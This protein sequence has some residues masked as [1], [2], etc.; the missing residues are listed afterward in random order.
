MVR[1]SS[2]TKPR[3]LRTTTSITNRRSLLPLELRL[4][5]DDSG[6]GDA[7]GRIEGGS[8][9]A[10]PADRVT[11]R[12]VRLALGDD[13]RGRLRGG[14]RQGAEAGRAHLRDAPAL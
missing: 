7:R 1:K 5:L 3:R 2:S 13:R 6:A 4:E 9:R 11:A 8:D 12:G 14:L 10:V